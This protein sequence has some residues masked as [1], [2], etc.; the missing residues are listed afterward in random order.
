[1]VADYPFRSLGRSPV[2]LSRTLALGPCG[3]SAVD[4]SSF[5]SRN[6]LEKIAYARIRIRRNS[7]GILYFLGLGRT[8]VRVACRPTLARMDV[9]YRKL[10]TG[11]PGDGRR[12][13]GFCGSC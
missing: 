6:S 7:D 9:D 13:I 1:M 2:R 3:P 4:S 5:A 10:G 12:R 8:P 11:E